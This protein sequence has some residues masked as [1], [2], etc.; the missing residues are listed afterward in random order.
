MRGMTRGTSNR[1]LENRMES[2][3]THAGFIGRAA[4][5]AGLLLVLFCLAPARGQESA[6]SPVY[7]GFDGEYGLKNS[8]SAQA[9]EQGIRIALHEINTAGGVL[10]GRPMKLMTRD[11]RSVPAR[12][13]DNVRR[14]A[15][16]E[17]LVAVIGGRFSPVML[18]QVPVV[19]ELGLVLLDAWGSADGIT[20]HD[21]RPSYTFRLS[22]KDRLGMPHMLRHAAA[23]G[24]DRVGLLV[25]NTGWGRSNV[26]AAQRYQEVDDQ[27]Q[28]IGPVWYN[29]GEQDM[30]RH[31]RTLRKL[32]A[33]AVILV[34]ND[35]EGST[36]VR[37]LGALGEEEWMPIIAHWGVTGGNMVEMSGPL[38]HQLDFSVIQTFSLFSAPAGKR[39]A[40]LKIA[41]RLFG[42]DR[43]EQVS[44][45][46]G[47]GHAYDL[48][49]ILARA[50][51]LAGST[52]RGA[53]RDALERVRDYRG[54]T[55]DYAR[56]F[57]E[58]DHDALDAAQLFMAR[59]REDGAIVPLP[60]E[61][62]SP[63]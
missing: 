59:F 8:T 23:K 1:F 15:Q 37:Q 5:L 55:G 16:V 48:T 22:L 36:L 35:I 52:D 28:V 42:I 38:L 61:T 6:A 43:P 27:P 2:D 32:G 34:A 60:R 53:V 12:G 51:E 3:G 46:V 14:F 45:P 56:P 19:H 20:E 49:H 47:F 62:A 57:S 26:K 21:F 40:V 11:N 39:E 50:V 63:K 33:E 58:T 44:S 25:P 41:S 13:I 18:E 10:G 30:L 4:A 17:D 9:I 29:W 54:L 7:L 24:L 31:Y